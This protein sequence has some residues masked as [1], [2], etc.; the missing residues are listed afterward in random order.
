MRFYE[1]KLCKGKLNEMQ[2]E[3]KV[4]KRA[5]IYALA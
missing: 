2:K 5:A 1:I 3:T 4:F